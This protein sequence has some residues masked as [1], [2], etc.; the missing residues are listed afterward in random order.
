MSSFRWFSSSLLKSGA[1][2]R[3]RRTS[4][5]STELATSET[6]EKLQIFKDELRVTVTV[7]AELQQSSIP[8]EVPKSVC[9]QGFPVT[10]V[11]KAVERA[12]VE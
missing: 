1:V 2:S 9:I 5:R 10:R 12:A 6:R 8:H 4:D 3:K 7:V 11:S